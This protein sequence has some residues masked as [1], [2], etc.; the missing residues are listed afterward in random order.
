MACPVGLRWEAA[1][2]AIRAGINRKQ[3]LPYRDNEG[4]PIV[5]SFLKGLDEGDPSES[6]WLALL[7]YALK[8][9]TSQIER[10]VLAELPIILALP[11]DATGQP[12]DIAST[13]QV[14]ASRLDIVVEPGNVSVVAEGTVGGYRAI[15]LGRQLLERGRHSACLVA[16]ADSWVNARTLLRLCEAGR[17]LTSGN[18]DGVIP[19]EAAAC[20]IL[21]RD[22][23]DALATVRGIGFGREPALISN[24]IPLRGEGITG[25]ARAALSEA[26]LALHDMDFRLSDAA[27]D[28]YAFKEQALVVTR[29]LRRSKATFPL[30]QCADTLGETGAAAGLCGLASAIAAFQRGYAPG[31]RAIG[32]VGNEMG[33]RAAVVLEARLP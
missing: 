3:E 22:G 14:L 31:P 2:A 11:A 19:G 10:G 4:E 29:L 18:A 25:A 21:S 27:G 12:P 28:S 5:G 20:L 24:D 9:A 30:W 32:F 6:R 26:G 13:V 16:A 23:K 7:L 8:D 33:Q 17:L 1:C 15:E